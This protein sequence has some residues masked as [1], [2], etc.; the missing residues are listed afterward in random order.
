MEEIRISW[1]EEWDTDVLYR[2][3][4]QNCNQCAPQSPIAESGVVCGPVLRFI[5]VNYQNYV[6]RGS[7]M[8]I[9]KNVANKAPL[10]I[11]YL[12]G[13]SVG[14]YSDCNFANGV[15]KPKLFHIGKI[16]N[17]TFQFYRYKIELPLQNYETLIRYSING[18]CETYYRFYIPARDTNF[19]SVAYSCNGFS[20]SVDTSRF[21]GSLWFDILN[22]HGKLHYNVML[23]GGDQIYSDQIKLHCKSVTKWLETRD[24][25]KKYNSK[26]DKRFIQ[27]LN[28]FYLREYIEW[29]GYGHWRGTTKMSMTTQRCLPIALACIPSV[30]MWDDHDIIDGFG[31]YSDSFMRTEVFSSIGK[32]AYKY[33]MLFQQQVSMDEPEEYLEEPSWILSDKPGRYIEEKS[34]SIFTRLGPDI[35]LLSVDCR[36][37]RQ[38]KQI[39]ENSTYN[40][41]FN[42]IQ[43]EYNLKKYDHL[44]VMLG[45]PIAYPRLVWL[46]KLFT[47]RLFSPLKWLSKKGLFARGLVNEFNGDVELLDDLND[48][49]CANHHKSERNE[50]IS[51][52]QDFGSKNSIRITI[53]S[54]D[55]HLASIGRFHDSKK[56]N[57]NG[58]EDVRL[59]F[60]ITSSAVVN[61][62][63]PDGMVKMLQK[64]TYKTHKFDDNTIED[65]LPIFNYES[66]DKNKKRNY[67]AFYNNRN[68]SDI[69]PV[70]NVL[71]NEHLNNIMKLEIGKFALPKK[72]LIGPES[73]GLDCEES[74][75]H[76]R[77]AIP[78][79]ITARGV[80]ATIHI[81]KDTNNPNSETSFYSVPIPELIKQHEHL[82]HTGLKHVNIYK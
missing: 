63:P 70:K 26:A 4:V 76:N 31:S 19:N 41:L 48:H 81:E 29:Y 78:Y 37:E 24:P 6:Y 33:Y 15:F 40:N 73:K 43:N 22:K 14:E 57:G 49:W 52:L 47:S 20:L 28:D 9:V 60:N 80:I 25:L 51:R 11:E 7:I 71:N 10:N 1:F 75:K 3:A 8:M 74:I 54:G 61:T 23:G 82:S 56:V 30:N 5:D 69:I 34:H 72:V 39:L 35:S 79:E 2:D 66:D 18:V 67:D 38:L 13:P 64:R 62:P 59:M 53:L 45:V 68:W 77:N 65:S 16:G 17:D 27:Q 12:S 32:V 21:Q 36:T 44:L 55:V 50:F 46:E 58:K 42:R